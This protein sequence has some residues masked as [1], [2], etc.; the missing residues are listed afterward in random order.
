MAPEENEL[1][2]ARVLRKART[3]MEVCEIDLPLEAGRPGLTSWK[4]YEFS[5]ELQRTVRVVAGF[6][7]TP[8]YMARLRRTE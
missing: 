4:S 5:P 1:V 6:G 2:V 8:F 7:M 3:P